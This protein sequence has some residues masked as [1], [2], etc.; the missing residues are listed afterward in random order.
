MK[1]YFLKKLWRLVQNLSTSEEW[2]GADE[3]VANGKIQDS[4]RRQ[5]PCLKIRDREQTISKI[6]ARDPVPKKNR[7]RDLIIG[8]C[9]Y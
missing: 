5:D 4:P 2:S 9:C 1:N 6:R 8:C 7:A 3:G